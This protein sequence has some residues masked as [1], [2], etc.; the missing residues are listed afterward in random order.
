MFFNSKKN[1]IYFFIFFI[2]LFTILAYISYQNFCILNQMETIEIL[3]QK[4]VTLV[5]KGIDKGIDID[6]PSTSNKFHR[7]VCPALDDTKFF[8]SNF[9]SSGDYLLQAEMA[10]YQ[11]QDSSS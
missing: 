9:K 7:N 11:D 5:D 3:L 6:I 10:S 4:I 2:I 8:G 1:Q